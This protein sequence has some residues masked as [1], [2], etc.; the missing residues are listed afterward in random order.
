MV[1]RGELDRRSAESSVFRDVM[2]QS[3]A[4]LV[5]VGT[6][7]K[8][9]YEDYEEAITEETKALLKGAHQQLPDCRIYRKCGN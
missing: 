4:N 7:N 2:E 5:E 8:T 6:T 9:H 1:S 3:G